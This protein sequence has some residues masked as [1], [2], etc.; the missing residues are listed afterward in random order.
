ML[1][2][3]MSSEESGKAWANAWARKATMVRGSA[4]VAFNSLTA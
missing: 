4:R 2:H 1:A 3:Y